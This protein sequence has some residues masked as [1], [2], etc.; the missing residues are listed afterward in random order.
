M[1]RKKIPKA[2]NLPKVSSMRKILKK[3]EE[4]EEGFETVD[5]TGNAC[6]YKDECGGKAD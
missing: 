2:F 3:G 4:W 6:R 5:L 1:K